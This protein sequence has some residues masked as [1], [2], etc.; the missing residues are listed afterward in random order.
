MSVVKSRRSEKPSP[1]AN[2]KEKKERNGSIS[3][4]SGSGIF[5]F[6]LLLIK[7]DL[8][9]LQIFTF[10]VELVCELNSCQAHVSHLSAAKFMNKTVRRAQQATISLLGQQGEALFMLP[11]RKVSRDSCSA[12]SLN[13][14]WLN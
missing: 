12:A 8:D 9:Y 1:A 11:L 4:V 2:I 10:S 5:V 3:P 14:W 6:V 13:S 7:C